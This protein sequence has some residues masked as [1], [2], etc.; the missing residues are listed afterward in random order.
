MRAGSPGWPSG[1]ARST[2]GST[3]S[4]PAGGP[5]VA[6]VELPLSAG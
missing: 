5:T 3:L 4:S 6:V 1:S 2:G